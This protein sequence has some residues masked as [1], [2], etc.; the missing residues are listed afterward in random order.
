[1]TE[2]DRTRRI[3]DPC[4]WVEVNC[5]DHFFNK[6]AISCP[7]IRLIRLT[8]LCNI[9]VFL[10]LFQQ[11]IYQ[12]SLILIKVSVKWLLQFV[13][14]S[15]TNIPRSVLDTLLLFPNLEKLILWDVEGFGSIV[16][17]K[18]IKLTDFCIQFKEGWTVDMKS[19][20]RVI[21]QMPMLRN[22]KIGNLIDKEQTLQLLSVKWFLMRRKGKTL[23]STHL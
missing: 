8:L 1:M 20:C 5:L 19:L 23:K 14:D 10:R 16:L 6:L 12:T 4:W 17:L 21:K 15:K 3:V 9:V 2:N 22:L 7:K 11:Y 18:M 13:T